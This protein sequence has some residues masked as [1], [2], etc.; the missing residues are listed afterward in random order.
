MDARAWE[1]K[2]QEEIEDAIAAGPPPDPPEDASVALLPFNFGEFAN[3]D[4]KSHFPSRIHYIQ[5]SIVYLRETKKE[6]YVRMLLRSIVYYSKDNYFWNFMHNYVQCSTIFAQ[7][8]PW[9][10][11]K[12]HTY[13]DV[14][15]WGMLHIQT[16]LRQ[17]PGIDTGIMLR[18][19]LDRKKDDLVYMYIDGINV[20]R[21]LRDANFSDLKSIIQGKEIMPWKSQ[22][23][24][25]TSED[26]WW[27]TS[28]HAI[29]YMI[30]APV[31]T[32]L[33][34]LA[35]FPFS[36]ERNIVEREWILPFDSTFLVSDVTF[37]KAC[38]VVHMTYTGPRNK[39]NPRFDSEE[40][41]SM[42]CTNIVKIYDVDEEEARKVI[43]N[44]ADIPY[45]EQFD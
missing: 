27:S 9:R 23:I 14:E 10:Y 15:S 7:Y 17:A 29:H 19:S 1:A 8:C 43:G 33:I 2:L 28:A 4:S 22:V 3:K 45:E 36:V 6:K 32:P 24:S 34:S 16:M 41:Y 11:T 39:Y 35:P 18:R 25:V 40:L 20:T 31:G 5:E 37:E 26:E 42:A 13:K 38:P 21:D 44:Y 12:H 30:S